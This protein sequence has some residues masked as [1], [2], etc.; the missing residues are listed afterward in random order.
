MSGPYRTPEHSDASL[1]RFFAV[2]ALWVCGGGILVA[3]VVAL[4]NRSPA[5]TPTEDEID[6]LSTDYNIPPAVLVGLE[7]YRDS[8]LPT[9]GFLAAVLENNLIKAVGLA[10]NFSMSALKDIVMWCYWE[11]P[12]QA[13]GSK[14]K[15]AAWLEEGR[16]PHRP[17]ATLATS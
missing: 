11:L 4:V 2:A 6:E 1:A 5:Q 3:L 16:L 10:D 7:L 17:Q 14:E 9:G 8:S 13:W 15:V 12:S